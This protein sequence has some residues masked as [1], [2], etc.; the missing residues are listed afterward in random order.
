MQLAHI[1]DTIT[2]QK[3][4]ARNWKQGKNSQNLYFL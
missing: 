2:R 4:L 3:F 1:E